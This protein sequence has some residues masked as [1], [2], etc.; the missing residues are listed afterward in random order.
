[1]RLTVH[2][3]AKKTG[4]SVRALHYY[5]E[6]HLLRPEEVNDSGYRFYGEQQIKRLS[7]ILFFRELEFPLREI[8]K[9]LDSPDFDE[10]KALLSHRHL[11]MLKKERYERLI[12]SV[13][14]ILKGDSKMDFKAFDKTEYQNAQKAYQEE[15][16]KRWGTSKEWKEYQEKMKAKP[17]KSAEIIEEGEAFWKRFAQHLSEKPDSP[18]VQELVKEWQKYLTENFYTCSDEMLGHLG[19][20]Y[21]SDERFT[22]YYEQF[23]KGMA[24][25]VCDAIRAY[26]KSH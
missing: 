18:A 10:R 21:V 20:M 13:D 14:Q 15:A 6:I 17:K 8:Q 1:M 11:L 2:D 19:E 5:D 26:C 25:F 16:K 22:S 23:G 24:Q 4:I 7:Q 3:L 12:K 9:I